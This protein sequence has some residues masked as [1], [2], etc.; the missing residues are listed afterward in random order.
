MLPKAL[1]ILAE[2]ISDSKYDISA[3]DAAMIML[4]KLGG[5]I[6]F[7]EGKVR[8]ETIEFSPAYATVMSKL[9][10][11][12]EGWILNRINMK[13]PGLSLYNL[14]NT[15]SREEDYFTA[16]KNNA[17]GIFVSTGLENNDFNRIQQAIPYIKFNSN[18]NFNKALELGD[19]FTEAPLRD[20]EI[21]LQT[22]VIPKFENLPELVEKNGKE[23]FTPQNIHDPRYQAKMAY[24]NL[25]KYGVME[26]K[27]GNGKKFAPLIKESNSAYQKL[28]KKFKYHTASRSLS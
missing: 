15:Y 25:G 3:W 27:L 18:D 10:K 4:R 9:D 8:D 28:N 2:D 16:R 21:I 7:A 17:R 26:G 1:E 5:Y 19:I 20:K 13:N 12:K 24:W 22:G 6:S 11:S 23:N 14:A